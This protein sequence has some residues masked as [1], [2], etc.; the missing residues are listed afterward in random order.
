MVNYPDAVNQI[1]WPLEWEIQNVSLYDVHI[2]QV[3]GISV[4]C[5][6]GHGEINTHDSTRSEL[7]RQ[8][9]MSSLTAPGI[10][11]YPIFEV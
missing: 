10:K 4:G 5:L 2:V 9:T 1:E 11:Y 6:D 7:R 3:T 8:Q